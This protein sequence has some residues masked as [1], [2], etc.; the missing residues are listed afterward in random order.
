MQAFPL[1]TEKMIEKARRR[2]AIPNLAY[3]GLDDY[4]DINKRRLSLPSPS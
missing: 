4:Y 2:E 3:G 1:S